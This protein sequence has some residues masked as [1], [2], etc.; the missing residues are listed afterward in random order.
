MKRGVL[1]A[2]LFLFNLPL[3][4]SVSLGP[5]QLARKDIILLLGGVQEVHWVPEL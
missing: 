1:C 3:S 4:Y 2:L 5:C